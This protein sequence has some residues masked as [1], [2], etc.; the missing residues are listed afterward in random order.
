MAVAQDTS[1][2]HSTATS[3]NTASQGTVFTITPFD[4]GT[5]SNLVTIVSFV[6]FNVNNLPLL[7]TLAFNGTGTFTLINST[8]V[9][10]NLGNTVGVMGV[11][12][13]VGSA[14]QLGKT[15]SLT[16]ATNH[17][18]FAVATSWKN[19]YQGGLPQFYFSTQTV[20]TNTM[21]LTVPD[22]DL[23]SAILGMHFGQ[24][25][26]G[27]TDSASNS[28]TTI[29]SQS[30]GA[31]AYYNT[32]YVDVKTSPS[33]PQ[34]LGWVV[35]SSGTYTWAG[36]FELVIEPFGWIA[37]IPVPFSICPYFA[38]GFVR[39]MVTTLS[40]LS[41][42]N[43]QA[44]SIVQDGNVSSNTGQ[45]V[46][47][48]AITLSTAAAVVHVGLPYTG[49]LKLLPLGGDGQT[50]NQGKERKMYGVVLKVW[51]SLGG[52]FGADTLVM[53]ALPIPA[54]IQTS[55]YILDPTYTG[56]IQSVPF[57]SKWSTLVQPVLQQTQPLPMTLLSAV[58]RSE[59]SEDK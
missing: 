22:A 2:S 36:Q 37:P 29:I 5:G 46:S 32:V 27:H 41:Y 43:G 42:L 14:T 6:A 16:F 57:E 33:Q 47:N 23:N 24:V 18:C 28:Q 4:I 35:S 44:V 7:P 31:N 15:I 45:V 52:L 13:L 1:E 55:G 19:A 51:K 20:G 17:Y 8:I 40:G 11:Y 26:S 25:Q 21:S 48:G 49:T 58:I 34:A 9:K 59:I 50:V 10:N 39:K 3:N 12:A 54:V 30:G 38:G 56:D 53:L